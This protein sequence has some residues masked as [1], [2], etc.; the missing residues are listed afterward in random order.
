MLVQEMFQKLFLDNF[1]TKTDGSNPK[2]KE[3]F[4]CWILFVSAP[5]RFLSFKNITFPVGLKDV[6]EYDKSTL[7][8]SFENI[9]HHYSLDDSDPSFF[10]Y[11]ELLQQVLP[12]KHKW[13]DISKQRSWEKVCCDTLNILFEAQDGKMTKVPADIIEPWIQF[14]L[15]GRQRGAGTVDS[16]AAADDG[17]EAF[18]FGGERQGVGQW[19]FVAAQPA[20]PDP[21]GQGEEPGNRR[22]EDQ[23]QEAGQ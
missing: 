17:T 16:G 7:Y 6:L 10:V 8:S 12:A 5:Q 2:Y 22:R 18:L 19:R 23:H 14:F 4:F 3:I 15:D 11:K 20:H 13:L 9:C 1:T 21:G